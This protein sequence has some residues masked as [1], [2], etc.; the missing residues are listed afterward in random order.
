MSGHNGIKTLGV[1]GIGCVS[2]TLLAGFGP[3]GNAPSAGVGWRVVASSKTIVPGAIV[4]RSRRSAWVL[5]SGFTLAQPQSDFPAGLHWNGRTWSAVGSASFPRAIRSTGIGCAA[6]SSAA[7]VWAFAGTT[8][9]GTFAASAGALRLENGRWK[10]VRQ[11]PAGLVTGCLV[12]SPTEAWVFGDGHVAPG[13]GTWHLHGRTW[14]PVTTSGYALD[15]ASAVNARNVWA[16]GDDSFLNPVVARWNGR[17]WVRNTKLSKVLPKTSGSTELFLGGITARGRDDV[18]F[19]VD[20]IRDPAGRA[21]L[22]VIVLRWNGRAWHKAR[23]ADFGYYLPGAV[24]DGQ[25]GWWADVLVSP[26]RRAVLHAVR[27]RWIKVPV[28]VRGCQTG[29][30][31]QIA[32]VPGSTSVLGLQQC[33]NNPAPAIVHVLARGPRL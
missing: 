32:P 30:L 20:I 33:P 4:V 15:N 19:R 28:S 12:E 16:E 2:L 31:T 3:A 17:S 1:A 10:L 26:S 21:T 7:N 23:P 29:Q 9:A 22:S 6:E 27:G 18:W 5:G 11:F 24:R 8:N 25:G 14:R 13:V